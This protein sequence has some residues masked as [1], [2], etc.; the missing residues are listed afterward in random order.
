[1]RYDPIHPWRTITTTIRNV[2]KSLQRTTVLSRKLSRGKKI[3]NIRTSHESI[4]LLPPWCCECL[5][6]RK[7]HAK[8]KLHTRYA[9]PITH[10]SSVRFNCILLVYQ[11]KEEKASTFFRYF[12]VFL[13]ASSQRCRRHFE[14][15][16]TK[17]SSKTS[18]QIPSCEISASQLLH[19]LFRFSKNRFQLSQR[20]DP[21]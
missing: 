20:F 6:V 19:F 5:H 11:K 12:R 7:D 21:A 16:T 13:L 10:K 4:L 8:T 18:K 3:R 15:V 14:N 2:P 1:M 17:S 9:P